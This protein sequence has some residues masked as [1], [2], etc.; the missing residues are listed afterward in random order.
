MVD[1]TYSKNDEINIAELFAA[2]WSHKIFIVCITIIF[3]FLSGYQVAKIERTYSAKATFEIN[4]NRSQGLSIPSQFGSIASLAGID[5][6]T[7]SESEVL[8]ER[9]MGREFILDLSKKLSLEQDQFFLNY[10]PHSADPTW[11]SA[12]KTLIGL[13]N[14]VP[15]E[16]YLKEKMIQNSYRKNVIASKTSAGLI[17]IS[18]K[19]KNPEMAAGYANDIMLQIRELLKNEEKKSKEFRLSY[20]AQTLADAL[21]DMEDAQIN[22]KNYALKNSTAAQEN[23]I[24]GSLKLDN[25]RIERNESI[26]YISV[27]AKLSKKLRQ[28]DLT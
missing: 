21:Q 12:L 22:L 8:L 11:K 18:V 7:F 27:L 26:E 9:I 4:Q 24:S 19:H 2:I 25:L 3:I 17:E 6:G 5:A 20:L 28:R 10:K 14:S 1:Q 13:E 16:R 15:D 23:F